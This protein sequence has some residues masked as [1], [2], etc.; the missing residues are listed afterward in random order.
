MYTTQL[1]WGTDI[2]IAYKYTVK[3]QDW[4]FTSFYL[5]GQFKIKNGFTV[6]AGDRLCDLKGNIRWKIYLIPHGIN[7]HTTTKDQSNSCV[8]Q[9]TV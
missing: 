5:K 8:P 3:T 9:P 6:I 1:I 7:L 2:R 4:H